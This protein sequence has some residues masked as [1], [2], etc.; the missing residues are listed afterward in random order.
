MASTTQPLASS[1]RA[2]WAGRVLSAL[3]ALFL[4][5]D[6]VIHVLKITPVVEA[7]AQLGY[8]LGVSVT[9][10]IIEIICVILYLIP[11]TSVLGAILLTGYLGGAVAAQVRVGAPLF[12]TTLFPVYVALL[13]WGGLYLRDDA[14]RA[15]IPLRR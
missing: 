12:S 10:G 14:A 5:F 15:L 9:L 4:L 8:P 3:G 6:G 1:N 7:F 2:L 11:R 13:I